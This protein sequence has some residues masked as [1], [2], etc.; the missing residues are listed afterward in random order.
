MTANALTQ[1]PKSSCA[2]NGSSVAFTI[3]IKINI[4]I[5][6]YY[7]YYFLSSAASQNRVELNEGF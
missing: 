2:A 6:S 5:T 3:T 7:W 4:I 1:G